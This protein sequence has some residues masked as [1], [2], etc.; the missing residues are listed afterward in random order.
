MTTRVDSDV[1]YIEV[2]R[3]ITSALDILHRPGNEWVA[4]FVLPRTEDPAGDVSMLTN[5]LPLSSALLASTDRP[6][7]PEIILDRKI[8]DVTLIPAWNVGPLTVGI[9]L[10][11]VTDSVCPRSGKPTLQVFFLGRFVCDERNAEMLVVSNTLPN[12]GILAENGGSDLRPHRRGTSLVLKRHLSSSKQEHMFASCDE[13]S[14]W[15]GN[16]TDSVLFSEYIVTGNSTCPVCLQPSSQNCSCVFSLPTPKSPLDFSCFRTNVATHMRLSRGESMISVRDDLSKDF[17]TILQP[18]DV[19]RVRDGDSGMA[20]LMRTLAIR[21][22]MRRVSPSR[23]MM[24]GLDSEQHAA[25]GLFHTDTVCDAS[26]DASNDTSNSDN[27]VSSTE[28]NVNSSDM[29][30]KSALNHIAAFRPDG[31]TEK[32][33]RLENVDNDERADAD[34]TKTLHDASDEIEDETAIASSEAN[35]DYAILDVNISTDVD[36]KL[37]RQAER[38]RKNRLAAARSNARRKLERDARREDLAKLR[39]MIAGLQKKEARLVRENLILKE[40]AVAKLREQVGIGQV[41]SL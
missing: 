34:L 4:D 29:L 18:C 20:L 25:A 35:M 23:L 39:V 31:S 24:S 33:I 2:A 16:Y 10:C 6:L 38:Q 30:I 8:V 36:E 17:T 15:S 32:F 13:A 5:P 37:R 28:K 1:A 27:S 11:H 3:S 26:N 14:F 41:E 22:R 19:P 12:T 40:Q 21:D 9:S 7:S